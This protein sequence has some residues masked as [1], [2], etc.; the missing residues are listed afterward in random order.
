MPLFLRHGACPMF[1]TKRRWRCVYRGKT[2]GRPT[3]RAVPTRGGQVI[4]CGSSRAHSTA[5]L[6]DT[7][8]NSRRRRGAEPRGVGRR[9]NITRT[10]AAN[11]TEYEPF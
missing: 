9:S 1:H 3:S 6:T 2:V 8:K 5:K 4:E 10:R 11:D 7:R